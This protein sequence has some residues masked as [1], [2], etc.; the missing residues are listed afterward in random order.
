M[1]GPVASAVG[2]GRR[3]AEAPL[4]GCDPWR[5]PPLNF[6]SRLKETIM[7]TRYVLTVCTG[8]VLGGAL[9]A[10]SAY[11]AGKAEEKAPTTGSIYTTKDNAFFDR[12][13]DKA[14]KHAREAEIAGN[15]GHAAEMLEYAQLSLDQAKQAQRAG[16]VPGLNEAIVELREALRLSATSYDGSGKDKAASD[17]ASGLNAA[18]TSKTN[19]DGT[20]IYDDPTCPTRYRESPAGTMAEAQT[21]PPSACASKTDANGTV[22]Y[23]DPT[24]PTR[25]RQSQGHSLQDATA[26]IREARMKLSQ[27]G[28]IRV[29]DAKPV[30]TK[31]TAASTSSR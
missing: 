19:A 21:A 7:T 16:N 31:P 27:A 17:S 18:C 20:V 28:G 8:L 14:V 30:D 11:A 29:T 1:G 26:H 24:C 9:I 15:Q 6:T 25:Y 2:A 12:S 13:I 22:I 3:R 10:G 5:N 23:D 4:N